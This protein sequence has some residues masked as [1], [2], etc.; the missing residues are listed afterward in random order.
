MTAGSLIRYEPT[1]KVEEAHVTWCAAAEQ[2]IL[3]EKKG[4]IVKLSR[5]KPRRGK[6]LPITKTKA[7]ALASTYTAAQRDVAANDAATVCGFARDMS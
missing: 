3:S 5:D 1:G 2:F 4:E 7:T 6:I